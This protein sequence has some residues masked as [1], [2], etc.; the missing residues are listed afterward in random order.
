[1]SS[2]STRAVPPPGTGRSACTVSTIAVRLSISP[3][4][5]RASETRCTVRSPERAEAGILR[6]GAASDQGRA[7]SAM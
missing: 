2:F 5:A 1:M 7:G 6:P 3:M 4:S